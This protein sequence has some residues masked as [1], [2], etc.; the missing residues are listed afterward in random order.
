MKATTENCENKLK[1]KDLELEQK[2]KEKDTEIEKI[3][4]QA[5]AEISEKDD[6]LKRKEEFLKVARLEA[7]R[8]EDKFFMWF[9]FVH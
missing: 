7:A 2:L 9:L 6:L 3:G 1:M 4:V 5:Q 8:L